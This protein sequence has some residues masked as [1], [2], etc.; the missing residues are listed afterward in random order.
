MKILF[1]A[2]GCAIEPISSNELNKIGLSFY[3]GQEEEHVSLVSCRVPITSAEILKR[4]LSD[5]FVRVMNLSVH[6]L[7]H[8]GTMKVHANLS[9]QFGRRI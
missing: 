4:E 6:F 7:I 8:Q 5:T 9:L 2:L 3:S 1:I